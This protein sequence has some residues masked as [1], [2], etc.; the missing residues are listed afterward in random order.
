VHIV[1]IITR[2][3]AVGGATIHVRD[4]ARGLLADGAQATIL[5]GGAGEALDEF[6]RSGVPCRSLPSLRR[7]INP[8]F[9]AAALA[10]IVAHLRELKPDLVSTHTAK[11]SWLGRVACRMLGV[12]ALF[13]PHGWTISDRISSASGRVFRLAE[14]VAAPLAASIV[15]VCDAEKRLAERHG[16][17]PSSKLAV[18]HNGVSDVSPALRANPA[19]DPPRIVMVA[20]FEPPKDHA[21][22]LRAL[23]GL[24]DCPW[25]LELIGAGPGVDEARRQA[26]S[27]GIENRILFPGAARDVAE[28]LSEAQMFV[29]TSRSEGFPRSILEAMRAGLPVVASDVGGIAEAV[30][31]GETGLVVDRDNPD[32]LSGA[33]RTLLENPQMRRRFGRAGRRRYE[34]NFTFEQMYGK[35]KA[36]YR[37]ILQ[38]TENAVTVG[39][40]R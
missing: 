20:R 39:G 21:I 5:V 31:H 18:I 22:L 35:T 33:L 30:L 15:N 19:L 8:F 6:A 34:F 2:G 11:A 10:E 40:S 12:P 25:E 14:R 27:L 24:Q 29:L 16:I 17:A 3:D 32:Q 37:E 38:T 4:M 36:L 7:S 1:F 9:D 13:T 28:R 23:A 26:A